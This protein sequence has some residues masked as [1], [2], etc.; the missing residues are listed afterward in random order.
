MSTPMFFVSPPE[1]DWRVLLFALGATTVVAALSAV[2]PAVAASRAEMRPAAGR[3]IAGSTRA[4]RRTGQ[5]V[6]ALQIALAFLLATTASLFTTSLVTALTADRGFDPRGLGVVSFSFPEGRY[7]TPAAH[8]LARD[9]VL[10][11]VRALPGVRQAAAGSAPP[12]T[13]AG[14]MALPG[15]TK[16]V[17]SLAIRDVGP[18]Y[19]A[20]AGIPMLAGRDFDAGDTA[21]SPHVAI[22]DEAG[23]R[24]VFGAESPIGK[25]FTYSPYVPEH[26]IV[27]VVGTV[28]ASDFLEGSHRVGMYL[29]DVQDL[30]MTS[31][32]IRA[33]RDLDTV[34]KQVR[35]TIEASGTGAR[36]R[37]AGPA[38]FAYDSAETF[39]A[40]RFYVVL[41]STFAVLALVTAAVGLYGLVAYSVGQRTREIGVRLALGSSLGGIRSL[42]LWE[43][44][45]TVAIGLA[46]G[47]LTTWWLT[48]VAESLLYGISPRDPRAF[49]AGA[50]VLVLA[51]FIAVAGPMRR[52]SR[53]DPLTALRAD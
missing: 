44:F 47:T 33:D 52:A 20:A 2:W 10:R 22:I 43:A 34:L 14:R 17:A 51:A 12:S 13:L 19:F 50:T 8:L 21:K 27:G 37:S 7:A 16:A 18:G 4:R 45:I 23:A 35:D 38:T 11:H 6:Q 40:P 29:L 41:V 31:F 36:V 28:A 24:R 1:L 15:E 49:A 26:T 48:G 25:R 39:A 32:L 3:Q 9:E 53:I 42:V 30:A 46:V 5:A